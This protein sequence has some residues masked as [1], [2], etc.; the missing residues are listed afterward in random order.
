MGIGEK[1]SDLGVTRKERRRVGVISE[2]RDPHNRER[3]SKTSRGL[4]GSGGPGAAWGPTGWRRGRRWSPFW[5]CHALFPLSFCLF[6]AFHYLTL[7]MLIQSL[8]N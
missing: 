6:I 5:T 8:S 3:D 4:L 1:S 2:R 7:F